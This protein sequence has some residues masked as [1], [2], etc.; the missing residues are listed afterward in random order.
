[1]RISRD[2]GRDAVLRICSCAR[3][4]VIVWCLRL[5]RRFLQSNSNGNYRVSALVQV[6][7]E[8]LPIGCMRNLTKSDVQGV[9]KKDRT[10]AI[11]ILLFILKHFK[12]CPLQSSP[13]YWRYNVPNVSS[14]VGMLPGTLFL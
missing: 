2:A 10:F 13:L 3:E 12:H 1:V 11:K 8:H 5:N 6:N 14:I 9:L 4:C 7:N